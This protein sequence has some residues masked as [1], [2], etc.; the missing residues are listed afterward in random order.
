MTALKFAIPATS[1]FRLCW[2]HLWIPA[3][4]VG[5]LAAS[6][7]PVDAGKRPVDY[8]I[9]VTGGELLAGAY[10]DS[11][12][13][14]VT[15]TL[16]PLGLRCVGSMSVDDKREDIQE[17]LRFATVKATLVI[18]T[19]GLGPTD[20]DITREALC[21]FTG[22]PLH[23]DPDLLHHLQCRFNVPR[24]QLRD[25]VRRQTRVPRDGTYLK[26]LNGTAVGLV[27]ERERSVIVALP[28]PPRELQPMVRDELVPYLK[29]R[30]GTRLPGCSLTLRFTGIGQSRI[31]QTLK[32]HVP[33][34]P[35]I[36]LT[37]Q[38]K[39]GRVDFTF[40]RPDNTPQD[41]AQLDALK[42]EILRHLGEYVYSDDVTSLEEH[43]VELLKSRGATLAL[44]EAGSGGLL[45]AGINGAKEAPRV[46]AGAYVAA[47]EEMLRRMLRVPDD[48]WTGITSNA[49]KTKL[50]AAVAAERAGSEWA[51]AVG[52]IQ[53]DDTGAH[54]VE[55]VF[56]AP[57]GILKSEQIRL[58]RSGPSARAMLTTQLLDHLRRRLR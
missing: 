53:R 23:E 30:F 57:G 18:V 35:K 24:D 14:F 4:L 3:L 42:Q 26:N 52:D 29:K 1:F 17:A 2:L 48:E 46:M 31:D 8:M 28:G 50:L 33:L 15:R 25:N 6:A 49:Q 58:G 54:Y 11:H 21:D 36:T 12:T 40:S 19:G 37:S 22:I 45:A 9:V 41:R 56:K 34:S 38:F 5:P 43:V 47:T 16:R 51:V 55:V 13:H 39:A 32:D 7:A 44:A 10:P 20:N 27:F